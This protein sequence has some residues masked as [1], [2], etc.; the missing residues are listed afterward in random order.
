MERDIVYSLPMLGGHRRS[1]RARGAAN[2]PGRDR[3]LVIRSLAVLVGFGLSLASCGMLLPGSG[4]N[5]SGVGNGPGVGD[6]VKVVFVAVDLKA[7]ARITGFN[8]ADAGDPEAQVQALE[9]WVNANG[10]VGGRPL[11]AVYRRYDP[12]NDS[13][14]AEEQLCNEITQDDRAFAAV[15]TGQLQA[16]ARPCY[17]KRGTIALDATL[18]A[19]DNAHFEELSPYLWNPS[20]PEYTGFVK[21]LISTLDAEAY[22]EGRDTVGIVAADNVVNRRV[23]E[24]LALPLLKEIGVKAEIGWVDTTDQGSLFQ[25]SDQAA[26]TFRTK[27]IDRVM[28]LGGARIASIFGAVAAAQSYEA[29]FALSSFDNPGFF[30]NNP[31]TLPP[32][33]LEGAV[34][35]GFNPS[36]DVPDSELEFPASDAEVTCLD[37]FAQSGISFESREAARVAMTFCDS[38]RLMMEAGNKVSGD[39]NATT[40]A[41]AAHSLTDF[42]TAAGFGSSLGAESFAAAG[43]YRVMRY[44]AACPC[45]KYEG[46]SVPFP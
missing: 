29:R 20:F 1:E 40:W 35:I 23:V 31:D 12:A 33:S 24:D 28:F 3:S 27:K 43:S 41:E 13:P 39:F 10:G 5:L 9:D 46:D 36:Q 21:A 11:E 16:N 37:I 42:E 38:A 26:L 25:G 14:A 45:F 22:F 8:L 19:T 15:L 18:V 32:S 2:G 44:D 30:V 34:G 4:A 17:A 6:S 7:V